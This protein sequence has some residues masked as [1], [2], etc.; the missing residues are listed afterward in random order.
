LL[1]AGGLLLLLFLGLRTWG[2]DHGSPPIMSHA[3]ERHYAGVAPR[4]SWG[5]LNPHRFENPPLLT[6]ALF[7]AEQ[8]HE[9]WMGRAVTHK[10]V[11]GGGLFLLARWIS[12]VLGTLT[13]L[14]VAASVRRITGRWDAALAAAVVIGCSFLHGRDS[15]YGVNDV[16]MT[17]LVAC[18]LHYAL[19]GL[20]NGGLRPLLMSAVLAG[21]AAATKYNG[22]VAFAL[23][24]AALLLRGG[25]PT[26]RTLAGAAC[27]G[28]LPFVSFVAA[29]PFAW[30]AFGEFRDGFVN[31]LTRWGDNY[32][33]GQSRDAGTSLYFSAS[34]A[35]LGFA[36]LTAALGGL[37]LLCRAHARVAALVLV[38]PVLYLAGMLSK[39]LF[40][41][42]FVLPLLPFLAVG[43]GLFWGEVARRLAPRLTLLRVGARLPLALTLLLVPAT[44]QPA[45]Q[46]MRHNQLLTQSHTLDAGP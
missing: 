45:I 37:V 14:V 38:F 25:R 5:D 34:L 12:A 11:S 30:I 28:A 23:A 29:N 3:D 15:H 39:T 2:L 13:A 18:S 1:L 19:R 6:Y 42:R 43:A 36:H 31:Q 8:L 4:L 32:I 41:W 26:L 10:W 33:W 46:L 27:L 35:M 40:F 7:A 16:P 9:L 22:A 44:L 21:L 20:Q 17:F 24:P